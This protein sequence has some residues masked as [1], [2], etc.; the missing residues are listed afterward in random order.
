MNYATSLAKVTC[1][2]R[3][4][5]DWIPEQYRGWADRTVTYNGLHA[6]VHALYALIV[7]YLVSDIIY[8]FIYYVIVHV[9]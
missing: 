6:S 2:I 3:G 5:I 9:V 7:T 1:E 8:L 4:S